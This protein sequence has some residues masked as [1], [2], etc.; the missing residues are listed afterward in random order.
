LDEQSLIFGG[1][2]EESELDN[3]IRVP[4]LSALPLIGTLFWLHQQ[5]KQETNVFIVVTPYILT[6]RKAA[7]DE[8][9]L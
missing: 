4:L 1:L 5:S 7:I 9:A 3:C 2:V 6:L 8:K